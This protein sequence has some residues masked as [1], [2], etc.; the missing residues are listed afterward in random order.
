MAGMADL[1]DILGKNTRMNI[2]PEQEQRLLPVLTR[3]HGCRVPAGPHQVQAGR[4]L[5]AGARS[6]SWPARMWPT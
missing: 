1:V 2:T 5:R 6:A 4:A 3:D